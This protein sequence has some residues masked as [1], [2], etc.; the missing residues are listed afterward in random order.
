MSEEML[1]RNRKHHVV[2][3]DMKSE[4]QVEPHEMLGVDQPPGIPLFAKVLIL[5]Y[6]ISYNQAIFHDLHKVTC[7]EKVGVMLWK[8][9]KKLESDASLIRKLSP[10]SSSSCVGVWI[11]PEL[12][13]KLD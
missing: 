7:R 11:M 2:P 12:V 3:T 13:V 4:W 9:P 8:L 1:P 10:F 5:A 6:E